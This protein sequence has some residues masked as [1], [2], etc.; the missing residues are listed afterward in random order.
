LGTILLLLALVSLPL[1]RKAGS[2]KIRLP[3]KKPA[4]DL[5]SSATPAAPVYQREEASASAATPRQEILRRYRGILLMLQKVTGTLIPAQQTL[6]E[7]AR[8]ISRT[9]GPAARY[10]LDLTALVERLLYS[11]YQPD[12]DDSLRSAEFQDNIEKGLQ[13]EA[14]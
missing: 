12:E 4:A 10:L 13:D 11:S 3:R 6:R 2:W 1:R 5:A 9:L 14:D 7:F 8:G